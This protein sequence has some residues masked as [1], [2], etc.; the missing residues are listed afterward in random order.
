M[1]KVFIIISILFIGHAMAQEGEI[2]EPTLI[3]KDT[4]IQSNSEK[5]QIDNLVRLK[6]EIDPLAPSKA[7]FYSAMLPGLGQ[8]YN[9]RYWKAPIV[10]GALG[11]GIYNYT[12]LNSEYNRFRDAFKQRQAGFTS[13]EFYPQNDGTIGSTPRVSN[14]TLQSAQ[15]SLQRQRDLWLVITIGLYAL[16]IIDANVDAHLKQYNVSED[17]S[18]GIE[19][20]Y[21]INELN[22]QP[23]AGIALNLN[24]K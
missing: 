2:S 14:N 23:N 18:L 5:I 10:W 20:F 4:I 15:E 8:M 9:K 11:W 19:P 3:S 22:N 17:L 12:N 7:A 1:H 13:D 21:R 6:E 16:N 24:F